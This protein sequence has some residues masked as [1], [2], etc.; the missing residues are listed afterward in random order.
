MP[1]A[2]DPPLAYLLIADGVATVPL[3]RKFGFPSAFTQLAN[4]ERIAIVV[5]KLTVQSTLR[6]AVGKQVVMV[7]TI[8]NEHSVVTTESNAIVDSDLASLIGNGIA[9]GRERADDVA[10]ALVVIGI[11]ARPIVFNI[12]TGEIYSVAGNFEGYELAITTANR[13]GTHL[14]STNFN[15]LKN[16][17]YILDVCNRPCIRSG[18][19]GYQT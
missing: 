14:I 4:P 19:A 10:I 7:G 15:D 17:V 13:V 6:I 8:V 9:L 1:H 12:N 2:I 18:S 5:V 11:E 16:A 3:I